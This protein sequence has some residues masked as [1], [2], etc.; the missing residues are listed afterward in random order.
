[1]EHKRAEQEATEYRGT[2]EGGESE[3]KRAYRGAQRLWEEEERKG[4]W[5]GSFFAYI[6]V[7]YMG[8]P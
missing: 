1:M 7:D 3:E 6:Q 2:V 5:Q 4:P 8:K